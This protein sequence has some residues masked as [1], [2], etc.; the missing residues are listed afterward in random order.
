MTSSPSVTYSS[1]RG[2]Q[3]NLSFR[4]VVMQG[5]AHDRGLFVPDS[6]P[7]VTTEELESW[8]GLSYADLAV[9]V[10]GKFVH[11]DQV[12]RTKLEDIVKRSCAAFRTK[13]VTPIV[14]HGGLSILVR[15]PSCIKKRKHVSLLFV[16]AALLVWASL[17]LDGKILVRQGR[18]KVR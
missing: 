15:S 12:P 10:I 18:E 17:L 14:Y 1:T 9:N 13:D 4:E 7:Q 3:K 5:L 6:F 8:R 11:D 16:V 2:G